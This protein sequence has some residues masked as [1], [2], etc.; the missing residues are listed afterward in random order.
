MAQGSAPILT[1]DQRLRVFISS[2]LGELAPERDAVEAAIRTLRLTPVR[3]ELGARAHGPADVYRSYLEQSDVFVGVY[4]ESYG[5]VGPEATISGIEDE[6]ERSRGRPQLIYV[7]EPAPEREASLHRL[8]DGV[9]NDGLASYR[10]F[11]AP[12]ELSELVLDDLA[13][14][15]TER[16]HG[17]NETRSLP[18]GTVTFVFVDMEGS[19]RLAQEHASSYPEIVGRFQSTLA[20]TVEECG[21]VVIDTEGDGAFCVFPVVDQATRAAVTF[22]RT[23]S[24]SDWPAGAVVLARVGIHT[25]EATRTATNYVGIEVHRAA[26]IGAAANGGQILVSRASAKLLGQSLLDGWRLSDLGSFSLK[27]LDRAEEL[28]QL[29]A[30]G[31]SDELQTPRARGARLVRLPAQLTGLVG[32]DDEIAGAASLIERHD[33]RLVTLTGPGGIGKTR[34]GVA[35]AERAADA[36][37]DGVYFVALA[38]TRTTDQVVSAIAGALGLR[39]EGARALLATVEDRLSAERTLVVLDNFEQVVE[40]R[41]VVASL[42]ENCPGLDLVVTSRTPLRVRGEI[43]YAVPP[44]GSTE[45]VRLFLERAAIPRPE[46]TPTPSELEAVEGICTRLDGLPLAIELAAARTRVLDPQSLLERLGRKLDIVG[47]SMPDLPERQRTLTA[48]IEWSHDL[49]KPADRTL[50][51]RLAVFVGGWTVDAAETVCGADGVADVLAGLERLSQHSLLVAEQSRAGLSRMRML[52]TIREFAADRLAGSTDADAM[53]ERHASYFEHVIAEMRSRAAGETA[54]AS[55]ARLDDDWDDVLACLEWRF[56]RGEHDRFVRTMSQTWRYIWLRDR[57]RELMPWLGE[58]Y[59]VRE[60]LEPALRGE[61][62]RLWGSACYQAGEY[63]PARDAIEEAVEIL[64]ETGPRDREAWSRTLLG[65]LLPYYDAN[66]ERP[67]A[68]VSRAVELFRE[69]GNPFGLATTLGM[70]GT[71]SALIGKREEALGHFAAGIDA[72]EKLGLPEI[73]G[74]N[75]TLWALTDVADDDI[76]AARAHLDAAVGAPLYLEGTAYCLD[77]YAAVLLAEGD[78]VGAATAVGAAEGLRDRTGIHVWPIIKMAFRDHLRALESAGSDAQ[79]AR[80]AGRRMS[81]ADAL[82]FVRAR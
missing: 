52:E 51:A 72:A 7:K 42:L 46:W 56:T 25:G 79:S 60:G 53:C 23:L 44:L 26:R 55:M 16:F 67:L 31:L 78:E 2:T 59:A 54:P 15:L 11:G 14:L 29:F 5:W 30:P 4:W 33:V 40:A 28:L 80:F 21:G 36:Y 76:A 24:E 47:G 41:T 13:V 19:T 20:R 58:V 57:V 9:R 73:I 10:E 68:E 70:L 82:A 77:G 48:T 22:Q 35:T 74:A 61:V 69:E 81:A 45:A 66:L 38:D 18:G 49:L 3:F 6:L 50:L 12:G 1:P 8:L 71:I 37:P 32:R 62:C 39:S 43:E 17:R 65:G 75:H 34:L 63:E 27:G 64:T